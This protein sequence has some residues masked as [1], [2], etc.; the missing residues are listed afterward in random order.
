MKK[1]YINYK[2][3]LLEELQDPELALNYLNETLK[4]EDRNVFLI[5]LKD[6]LEAQGNDLSALA[7]HAK[8]NR[9]NLYRMLSKKGNPRWDSLTSLFNALDLQVQLSFKNK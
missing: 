1:N 5:A 4:D 2:D 6:V 3:W 8:L 9:Q 7:A